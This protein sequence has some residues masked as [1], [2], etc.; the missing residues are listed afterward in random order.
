MILAGGVE[1]MSRVPMGSNGGALLMDPEFV[2]Q[3]TSVPQGIAADM[4]ATMGG[5]IE[6][7]LI[8]THWSPKTCRCSRF[9]RVLRKV[10]DTRSR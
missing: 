6:R 2:A 7:R 8:A 4:V 1:S 3:Q 5:G 9:W 10:G